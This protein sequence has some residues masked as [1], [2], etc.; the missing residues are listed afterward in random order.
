MQEEKI[1][2]EVLT[3]RKRPDL[4]CSE[5][6]HPSPGR[7]RLRSQVGCEE[8]LQSELL[9]FVTTVLLSSQSPLYQMPPHLGTTKQ[10]PSH[11]QVRGGNKP[12]NGSTDLDSSLTQESLKTFSHLGKLLFPS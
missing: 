4:S 11:Q 10:K 2:L 6:V 9:S 12:R 3:D 8:R 7:V 5:N 1:S